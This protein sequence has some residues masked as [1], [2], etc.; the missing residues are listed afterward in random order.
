MN[1]LGNVHNILMFA[2]LPSASRNY[3]DYLGILQNT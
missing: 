2:A 3:V 1:Y